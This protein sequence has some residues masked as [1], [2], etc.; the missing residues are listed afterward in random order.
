MTFFDFYL[1]FK[2]IFYLIKSQK[3]DLLTSRLM[4]R[5]GT[6]SGCDAALRPRG[7]AQ[8]AR[9]RHMWR[10]RVAGGHADRSTRTP[11]RG[12]TGQAGRWRAHGSSGALVTWGDGNAILRKGAPLFNR[13]LTRYFRRVGLCSHTVLTFCRWRGGLSGVGFGQNGGDRSP[14]DHQIETR[15]SQERRQPNNW[16]R[17][18]VWLTCLEP[19]HVSQEGRW[20]MKKKTA[21]SPA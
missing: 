21:F 12:A 11:V 2:V 15:V 8:A 5:A 4:W 20:P 1:I 14:R 18:L 17:I 9:A 10:W 13:N 3:G 16:A 19:R 6:T 7:R